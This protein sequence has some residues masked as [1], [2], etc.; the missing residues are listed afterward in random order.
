MISI[1]AGMTQNNLDIEPTI[2]S[3]SYTGG[4]YDV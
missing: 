3:T 4:E 1:A 2:I